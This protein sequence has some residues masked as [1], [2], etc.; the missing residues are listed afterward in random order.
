MRRNLLLAFTIFYSLHSFAQ[1]G[2]G[3]NTPNTSAKL[4]IT[5]TDKGLLMPR[6]TASQ[7]G[8][9]ASPATGLLVF[10]TDAPS[11]FYYYTGSAWII[12]STAENQVPAGTIMPYAGSSA[13]TGWALCDGSAISRSTYSTLY[14]IVSTTY[15]SGDGSSTFNIP[16]LRGRTVFGK[17]NMGGSTASRL[18]SSG[19]ITGTTLGATGGIQT[20]SLAT[21]EMPSHSHTYKDAYFAENHSTSGAVGGNARFGT[22]AGTD[23]DNSFFFRTSSNG[24]TG[25][26]N[27][28]STDISTSSSGSG[29]AFALINPG[30]V[31]NYIIKL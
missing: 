29:T 30:I 13:P 12:L 22:S 3:T 27:D 15:G 28:A 21:G 25:N 7:R 18:T 1:V 8:L 4:D 6:M 31:L 10:Q 17:D 5:A 11:G 2:I 20:K 9:I 24:H 14:S 23:N 19:G 26:Y 16:D